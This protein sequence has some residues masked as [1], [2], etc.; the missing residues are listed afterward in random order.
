MKTLFAFLILSTSF[1]LTLAQST[2]KE[3]NSK[4]NMWPLHKGNAYQYFDYSSYMEGQ[5]TA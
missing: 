1:Y 4:D 2:F 5:V 3:L